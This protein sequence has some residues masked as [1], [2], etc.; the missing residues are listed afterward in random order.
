MPEFL[1]ELTEA[2]TANVKHSLQLARAIT[3]EFES[4]IDLGHEII[5]A[6]ATVLATDEYFADSDGPT[7]KWV[8]ESG[9]PPTEALEM[10]RRATLLGDAQSGDTT[11]KAKAGVHRLRADHVR[12]R[13]SLLMQRNYDLGYQQVFLKRAFAAFGYVR[14]QIETA[15]LVKLLSDEPLLADDWLSTWDDDSGKAFHRANSQK[16]AKTY[17]SWGLK[18]AYSDASGHSLHPRFMN[19]VPGTL[20]ARKKIPDPTQIGLSYLDIDEPGLLAFWL[21]RFGEIHQGLFDQLRSIYP[22]A[23]AHTFDTRQIDHYR[24]S[25]SSAKLSA[26]PH[27]RELQKQGYNLHGNG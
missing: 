3:P 22:E 5:H 17:E 20:A 26:R 11:A 27:I 18:E 4:Y 15:A 23:P 16:L 6:A 13:L 7:E 25:L 14:L 10:L 2:D 9:L 1:R 19:V 8:D 12:L 24:E 21:I